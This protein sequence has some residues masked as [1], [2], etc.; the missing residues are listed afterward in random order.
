MAFWNENWPVPLLPIMIAAIVVIVLL[1]ALAVRHYKK[2]KTEAAAERAAEAEHPVTVLPVTG[3]APCRI[4]KVH[5]QGAR[6]YQEDCFS[7]SPEEMYPTNG[8]LAVV[9]DGMG[10]LD[11]GDQVSQMAVSTM[12]N[13]FFTE[14]GAPMEVLTSL[15]FAVNR[16]VNQLLGVHNIG[17]CGATLI[18]GLLKEGKFYYIGIGDSRICLYR[19]GALIQLNREHVYRNELLL[20]A[21]NG[22]GTL[23]EARTH[24]KAAGLTSFVGMG[25]IK[26]LDLPA[27]PVEVRAKDRLILMSDGVYNALTREEISQALELSAEE[28][29]E[30][31]RETVSQKAWPGQDNYTAIILE[32]V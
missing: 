17:H 10:G 4:G 14:R 6:D 1:I 21:I 8:L 2:K 30:M 31:L 20:R 11:N 12:M 25:M 9:S 28:G 5:E 13:G 7:V 16:S 29:A 32:C 22:E 19:D 24:P 26:H 23:E 18:A 15:L 27:E 3:E